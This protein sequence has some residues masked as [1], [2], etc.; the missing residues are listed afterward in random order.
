MRRIISS[1]A[2]QTKTKA[3]CMAKYG[4][5]SVMKLESVVDKVHEAK[6]RNGSWR[7]S[8]SEEKMYALLCE[9]FGKNDV[10]RQYKD[11]Q[12][13]PFHSDFYIKSLDL[14]IELNATW[15]HGGNWFDK[16]SS[17]DLSKLDEWKR[18]FE[19]G[20][21]F[22][23]VAIDVWTVRDVKK[24]EIALQNGLNYLVFW[25]NDLSDF[26][27]WLTADSLTLNNIL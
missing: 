8:A 17:A 19:A 4:M 15:L 13:Y 26:M 7:T 24:H 11:P 18:K 2:I 22:Y 14:F 5:P 25:K 12:R 1:D 21:K 16:L 23:A 6:R 27:T 3:T 20:S 10:V 9:R